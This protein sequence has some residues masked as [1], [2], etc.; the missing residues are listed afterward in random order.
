MFSD[1]CWLAP[2]CR[3]VGLV[4]E[5]KLSRGQERRQVHACMLL[6]FTRSNRLQGK[7]CTLVAYMHATA[8]LI[9][10]INYY[11]FKY[12]IRELMYRSQLEW[13]V[14]QEIAC[15]LLIEGFLW[16]GNNL[17]P[18]KMLFISLRVQLIFLSL[19]LSF[20]LKFLLF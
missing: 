17:Q 18:K 9:I 19:F 2:R 4:H 10:G 13:L 7:I 12:Y 6:I 5:E 20:S 15:S 11:V 1:I 3:I 16:L 14:W 8:N